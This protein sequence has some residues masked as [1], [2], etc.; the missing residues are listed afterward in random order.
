[1][2]FLQEK[3]TPEFRAE[4]A[5]PRVNFPVSKSLVQVDYFWVARDRGY[6]SLPTSRL[7]ARVVESLFRGITSGLPVIHPQ[8][9]VKLLTSRLPGSDPRVPL[10]RTGGAILM[11]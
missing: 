2:R 1:M 10:S 5:S 9:P 6:Q 8:S 11:N 4:I 3:P 7:L